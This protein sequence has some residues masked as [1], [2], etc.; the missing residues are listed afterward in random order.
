MHTKLTE[1]TAVQ[2]QSLF[3]NTFVAVWYAP[4]REALICQATTDYIPFEKFKEAFNNCSQIIAQHLPQRFIFDKRNLKAF[5]QPSMVWYFS[6]WKLEMLTK[7]GLK[8]HRKILPNED[9]FV[10]CVEA[11]RE[12]IFEQFG[13]EK[14]KE[15]H[16][17]YRRDLE[18][19]LNF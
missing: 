15:L 6:V 10:K 7:Y 2:L 4:Q 12:E 18:Q 16:I 1:E 17:E 9:W 19:A 13:R 11:G 14:F 5:H 3:D 8:H